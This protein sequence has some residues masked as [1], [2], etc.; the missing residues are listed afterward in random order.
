MTIN[1]VS[2]S[3]CTNIAKLSEQLVTV[4]QPTFLDFPVVKALALSAISEAASAH[5]HDVSNAYSSLCTM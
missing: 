4:I 2:R 1:T 3:Y 5:C